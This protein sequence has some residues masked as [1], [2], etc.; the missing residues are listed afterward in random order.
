MDYEWVWQHL[1]NVLVHYLHTLLHWKYSQD[2]PDS[3]YTSVCTPKVTAELIQSYGTPKLTVL[4]EVSHDT[5]H[6]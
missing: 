3:L 4:M 2:T 1:T 5:C 6:I